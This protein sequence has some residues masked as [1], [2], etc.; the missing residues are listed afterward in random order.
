MQL[1]AV[2]PVILAGGPGYRLKPWSS[3]TCPKP[4]LKIRGVSL[5]QS[6]LQR[7]RNQ[8]PLIVCNQ[9]YTDLARAQAST[10]TPHA[11]FLIEPAVR[12]TAPA[13]AAAAAYILAEKG[14]DALMLVMPSDHAIDQPDILMDAVKNHMNIGHGNI[15]SFGIKP[16][17]ASSRFGYIVP[18]HETSRFIEK[19][20]SAQAL[21]L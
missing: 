7:V 8:Q 5:L 9:N 20:R 12:N 10:V 3:P 17:S 4:F 6:T 13:V 19:P 21:F 11:H 14:P 15:L 2:T 1:E 18:D 16:R